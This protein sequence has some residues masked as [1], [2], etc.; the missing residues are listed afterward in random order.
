MKSERLTI[1]L[2]AAASRALTS[3]SG[4]RICITFVKYFASAIRARCHADV[5]TS[6][7]LRVAILICI[8]GGL[9]RS[10]AKIFQ[11]NCCGGVQIK[12]ATINSGCWGEP[13]DN[14]RQ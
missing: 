11:K 13:S 4:E 10:A 14:W 9:A 6:A 5:A 7:L 12:F 3:D 1:C 2:L 8:G